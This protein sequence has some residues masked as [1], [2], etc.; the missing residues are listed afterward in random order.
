MAIEIYNHSI[1]FNGAL[2][3]YVTAGEQTKR[4]LVFLHGAPW[5]TKSLDVVRELAKYFYVVAPEQPAFCRSDPLPT[6]ANLPEQY[7]DVVHHILREEKLD[8]AKPIIMAQSFGGNAAHGYL[9]RH[10]RN[11]CALV[12]TDA[13]MPTMPVPRTW[14]ILL[15]QVFLV[16]IGGT[17]VPLAP[18]FV[19]RWIVKKVWRRY[20]IVWDALETHP[21]RVRALA[22]NTAARTL[23]SQLKRKPYMEVD[24]STCPILMLWGELDGEERIMAEGGGITHINIARELYE[25][26]KKVNN[27]SKFV[28]LRGGHTILYDNPPYVIGEII[29]FMNSR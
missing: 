18:R 26:I 16:S 13:I 23:W 21:K 19:K 29:Q 2:I 4:P 6:Y 28:T 9:K 3:H 8:K 24:Y 20:S 27:A 5:S 22:Y 10:P 17:F 7:A 1:K 12:L 11:I 15:Q 25:R 14:R